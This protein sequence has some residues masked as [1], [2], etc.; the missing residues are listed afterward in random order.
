MIKFA[1]SKKKIKSS[2][3]ELILVHI[4]AS[5]TEI[6]EGILLDSGDPEITVS[7]ANP[8]YTVNHGDIVKKGET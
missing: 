3:P 8:V 2:I 5:V 6:G 4:S 1:T 7:P